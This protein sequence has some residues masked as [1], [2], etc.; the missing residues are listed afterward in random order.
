[1]HDNSSFQFTITLP[2][3]EPRHRDGFKEYSH[4]D[5][6]SSRVFIHQVHHV[7]TSLGHNIYISI[8]YNT[9]LD[10]DVN[11]YNSVY[12]L[13]CPF[14][15][16]ELRKKMYLFCTLARKLKRDCTN[17]VLSALLQH[18]GALACTHTNTC[19]HIHPHSR[20]HAHTNIQTRARTHARAH[21]Q[22]HT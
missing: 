5:G 15:A 1:L 20:T 6:I 22:T 3:V 11:K 14:P 18:T 16:S 2:T 7:R 12:L 19:T 10:T 8:V 13:V 9:F 4:Q 17:D 21:T